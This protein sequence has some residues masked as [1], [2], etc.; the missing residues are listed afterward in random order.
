[1]PLA[2]IAVNPEVN[3][4]DLVDDFMTIFI[5]GQET[6]SNTLSFLLNEV[7]QRPEIYSKYVAVIIS[8]GNARN[9]N[10]IMTMIIVVVNQI[11]I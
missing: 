6:T 2:F 9:T 11:M 5:A 4:E 7:G 8:L 10:I 1:M 3:I